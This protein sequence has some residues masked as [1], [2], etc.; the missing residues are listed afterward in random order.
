V[1]PNNPQQAVQQLLQQEGPLGHGR[2]T[3]AHVVLGQQ[4][5]V[6]ACIRRGKLSVRNA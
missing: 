4:G 3:A 6:Q 2:D 5:L 1:L